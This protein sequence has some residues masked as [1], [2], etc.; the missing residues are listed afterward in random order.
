MGSCPFKGY[1]WCSC[2]FFV[3]VTMILYTIRNLNYIISEEEKKSWREF[4]VAKCQPY[5]RG[6]PAGNNCAPFLQLLL[7]LLLQLFHHLLHPK[8]DHIVILR[9]I[10]LPQVL[11]RKSGLTPEASTHSCIPSKELFFLFLPWSTITCCR[12]PACC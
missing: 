7:Q 5:E 6:Q 4:T 10:R 3:N 9:H 1:L 11:P 2:D 8:D 12:E